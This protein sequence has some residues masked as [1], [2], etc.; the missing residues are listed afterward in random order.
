M[1][2][3]RIQKYLFYILYKIFT[4]LQRNRIDRQD[5][6]KSCFNK[7]YHYLYITHIVCIYKYLDVF[8]KAIE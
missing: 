4:N 6:Y 3:I 8:T 7:K 1:S 5:N 2:I